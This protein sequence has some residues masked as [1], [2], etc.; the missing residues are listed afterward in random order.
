MNVQREE[1]H[2]QDVRSGAWS[3]NCVIWNGL[4]ES[5]EAS[6]SIAFSRPQRCERRMGDFS[7]CL[8]PGQVVPVG[9]EACDVVRCAEGTLQRGYPVSAGHDRVPRRSEVL[10]DD[11]LVVAL[12]FV[13]RLQRP[14]PASPVQI[15]GPWVI[16]PLPEG[17]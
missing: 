4:R 13:E 12:L 10:R 1:V 2:P 5:L 3:R 15:A 8:D 9:V 6:E 14:E 17:A 16:E 7:I 11:E